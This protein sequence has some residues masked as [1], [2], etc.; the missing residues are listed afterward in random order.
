MNEQEQEKPNLS[1]PEARLAASML[2]YPE[3]MLTRPQDSWVRAD[4]L[5]DLPF[6]PKSKMRCMCQNDDATSNLV[7]CEICHRYSHADCYKIPESDMQKSFICIYCQSLLTERIHDTIRRSTL[8]IQTKL[9]EINEK[10]TKTDSSAQEIIDNPDAPID[11]FL[12]N[13]QE[14]NEQCQKAWSQIPPDVRAIRKIVS[15]DPLSQ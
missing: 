4:R 5:C 2:M 11:G 10:L 15:F 3:S 7:Q 13:I 6:I 9:S 1:E 12:E 14:L 8:S